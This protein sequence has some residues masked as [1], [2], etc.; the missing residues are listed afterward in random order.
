MLLNAGVRLELK[1]H[2]RVVLLHSPRHGSDRFLWLCAVANPVFTMCGTLL[3]LP[4]LLSCL[5][6]CFP[7]AWSQHRLGCTHRAHPNRVPI[8]AFGTAPN[9][10]NSCE[11]ALR[12]EREP[13]G[14]ALSWP[15]IRYC[16]LSQLITTPSLISG[17]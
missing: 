17:S 7:R 8:S 11:L 1:H 15:W 10:M 13:M 4:C 16:S 5:L 14:R 9:A 6:C 3:L 12:E 2:P